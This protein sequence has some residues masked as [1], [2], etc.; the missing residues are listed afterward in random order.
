MI[1]SA[2]IKIFEFSWNSIAPWLTEFENHKYPNDFYNS[3][4][5]KS[6]LFQAV[7][8]YAAFMYT[9]VNLRF[10]KSGCP[11]GGC[12]PLLRTQLIL[13]QIILSMSH[14][15]TIVYQVYRV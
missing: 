11:P 3:Y 10:T 5:W 12:L 8:S 13:I 15:A 6:F 1:L 7:N 2:Q 4:L 14:V 9:A